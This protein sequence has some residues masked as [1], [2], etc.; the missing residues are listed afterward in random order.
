MSEERISYETTAPRTDL[1]T[2][3]ARA[4]DA[5]GR[6]C[7]SRAGGIRR[8]HGARAPHPA[9]LVKRRRLRA[10]R[11]PAGIGGFPRS[12]Y[13]LAADPSC[14]CTSFACWRWPSNVGM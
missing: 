13:L 8:P 14:D 6:P 2:T 5:P 12:I 3:T 7:T 1:A 10:D 11:I 4:T 9:P